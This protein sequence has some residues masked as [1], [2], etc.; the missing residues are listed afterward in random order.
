[1]LRYRVWHTIFCHFRSFFALLA[2][3]W[4]RKLKFGKNVKR[5]LEIL[6]FYT[7]APLIKII[8]CM[9]PEIR[10]APDIIFLSYW[11]IFCPFTP[12]RAQK[13]KISKM[14]KTLQTSSFYTSVPKI[15]IICYTFP[16]IWP[17]RC[18]YFLFWAIFCHFTPITAPKIKISKKWKKMSGDIIILHMCTKYYD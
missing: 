18:N 15:M 3:Y 10:N 1:M 17:N 16:E 13:M 5:R 14:K 11:A 8:W 2:H 9:V 7:C 6:S 4:T 12:L